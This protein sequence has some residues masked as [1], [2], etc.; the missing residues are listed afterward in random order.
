MNKYVSRELCS[1]QEGEKVVLFKQYWHFSKVFY[2]HCSQFHLKIT[3]AFMI[4]DHHYHNS[5]YVTDNSNKAV[6]DYDSFIG[7]FT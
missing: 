3:N 4:N 7:F 6:I 1:T 2:L 5:I